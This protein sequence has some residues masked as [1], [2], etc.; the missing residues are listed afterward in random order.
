MEVDEYVHVDS[1]EIISAEREQRNYELNMKKSFRKKMTACERDVFTVEET[2]GG[3]KFMLNT[4]TFE[5]FRHTA[6]NFYSTHMSDTDSYTKTVVHDRNQ[7]QVETRFKVDCNGGSYT[8]N[9]YHTTCTLLVNGRQTPYFVENHLSSILCSIESCLQESGTTL[10][11]INVSIREILLQSS[12]ASQSQEN[13]DAAA[14]DDEDDEVQ[15]NFKPREMCE[16][17]ANENCENEIRPID[18]SNHDNTKENRHQFKILNSIHE[19]VLRI[20]HSL[21]DHI[22]STNAN[23]AQMRDELHSLKRQSKS[24]SDFT[25]RH[26]EDV[27]ASN[28]SLKSMNEKNHETFSRKLQTISDAIKQLNDDIK[29]KTHSPTSISNTKTAKNAFEKDVRKNEIKTKTLLIGDSILKNVKLRSL[30]PSVEVDVNPGKKM[31]NVCVKLDYTSKDEW[32]TVIIYAGGNDAPV[33]T[34]LDKIYQDLT[35]TVEQLRQCESD[36]H[37]CTVCPRQDADVRPVNDIIR[38]VCMETG[39]KLIDV[40]SSFVYGD[41]NAVEHYFLRDGI[42]LSNSGE[43]KLIQ[44]IDRQAKILAHGATI[45]LTVNTPQRRKS[46]A[47]PQHHQRDSDIRESHRYGASTDLEQ[48]KPKSYPSWS[49]SNRPHHSN[50]SDQSQ[51]RSYRSW[52]NN[53]G[54]H[55]SGGQQDWANQPQHSQTGSYRGN[56]QQ[57]RR[58]R[59]HPPMYARANGQQEYYSKPGRW[60]SH[61]PRSFQ[62]NTSSSMGGRQHVGRQSPHFHS[63]WNLASNSWQHHTMP[64]CHNCNMTNHSTR[65]CRRQ[66]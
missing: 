33:R 36:V 65:E 10:E 53:N 55:Q 26:I 2:S 42:H 14:D 12:G 58:D 46:S 20:E 21:Q 15:F 47:D 43:A 52:A 5:V 30:S 61:H 27:E 35:H 7:R 9:M 66:F 13:A 16:A 59:F 3:I 18:N 57:I 23:F 41:G 49:N 45:D 64:Y 48:T 17:T 56:Q 44:S 38:R 39:S 28:L 31:E 1:T 37:V 11:E 25:D 4:G 40:Y 51:P 22:E 63:R 6:D 19:A 24:H 54:S 29:T 34:P 62:N 8:M 32:H 60:R 50:G